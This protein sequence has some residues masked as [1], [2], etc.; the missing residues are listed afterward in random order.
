MFEVQ[1]ADLKDKFSRVMFFDLM[2]KDR[3]QTQ[4]PEITDERINA[5][6]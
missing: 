2:G 1:S 4:L 3:A 5:N 6:E